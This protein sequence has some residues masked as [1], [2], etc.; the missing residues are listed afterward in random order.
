MNVI[1]YALLK[2]LMQDPLHRGIWHLVEYLP[3][4]TMAIAAPFL[5]LAAWGLRLRETRF[6]L[7]SAHLEFETQ[8]A[9]RTRLPKQN[10]TRITWCR[11]STENPQ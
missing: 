2:D 11:S 10:G 6:N 4:T 3:F 7:H 1:L 8:H 9:T 5:K